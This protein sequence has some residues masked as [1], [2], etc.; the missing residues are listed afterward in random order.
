MGDLRPEHTHGDCGGE[1]DAHKDS[2][3]P[4]ASWEKTASHRYCNLASIQD[5]S[6]K[7][8]KEK[9]FQ[10]GITIG[11]DLSFCPYRDNNRHRSLSQN[12]SYCAHFRRSN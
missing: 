12:S 11:A 5:F 4:G 2:S 6:I 8:T 10:L 3:T 7:K 1:L 9:Y